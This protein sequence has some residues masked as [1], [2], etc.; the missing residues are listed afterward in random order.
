M[1]LITSIYT[2]N[3]NTLL[4]N[5]SLIDVVEISLDR[6]STEEITSGVPMLECSSMDQRNVL[7]YGDPWQLVTKDCDDGLLTNETFVEG[8]MCKYK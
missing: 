2:K 6:T 1:F 5:L 3:R 8:K 7:W 4:T